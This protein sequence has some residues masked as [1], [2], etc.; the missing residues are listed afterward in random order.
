MVCKLP[1]A[2]SLSK[3]RSEGALRENMAKADISASAKEMSVSPRRYSGMCAKPLRTKAKSA[4]AERC[5]RA[6]GTTI[7]MGNPVQERPIVPVRGYFR[8]DVYERPV[9]LTQ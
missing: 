7:A 8:I 6:L 1:S 9:Q 3:A 5:L 2:R 4:S